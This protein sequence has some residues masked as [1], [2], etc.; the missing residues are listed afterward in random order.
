MRY[1]LAHAFRWVI[2]LIIIGVL[3]AFVVVNVFAF[4]EKPTYDT[5]EQSSLCPFGCYVE[6]DDDGC[7]CVCEGWGAHGIRVVFP[8]DEYEP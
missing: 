6:Y 5:P 1:V 8:C 4:F 3:V 7:W 2:S